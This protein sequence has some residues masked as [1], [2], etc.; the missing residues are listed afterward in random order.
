LPE[1]HRQCRHGFR[2][3]YPH[4]P[5]AYQT[6]V[7]KD[8]ALAVLPTGQLRLPTGA[9]RPPLLPMPAAYQRANWRRAELTLRA[10][11]YELCL[12]VK[13]EEGH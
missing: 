13:M 9:Q 8:Q 11:H 7:G 5:K 12:T 1:T 10:D 6:A 3:T 4:H 2:T